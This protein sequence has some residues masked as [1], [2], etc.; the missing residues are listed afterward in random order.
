LTTETPNLEEAPAAAGAQRLTERARRSLAGRFAPIVVLALGCLF[1]GIAL[2]RLDTIYDGDPGVFHSRQIAPKPLEIT[3]GYVVPLLEYFRNLFAESST[4]RD[5]CDRIHVEILCERKTEFPTADAARGRLE[6]YARR[7]FARRTN[8][9]TVGSWLE[10]PRR[11]VV[12]TVAMYPTDRAARA[13]LRASFARR[14]V[15]LRRRRGVSGRP[16]ALSA[17]PEGRRVVVGVVASA[18]S[19]AGAVQ[20]L[21]ESRREVRAYVGVAR[22]V[23]YEAIS[24]GPLV[25]LLALFVSARGIVSFAAA[26]VVAVSAI[27]GLVFTLALAIVSLP[28]AA[29]RRRRRRKQAERRARA[30]AENRLPT[31]A[32]VAT[33]DRD[34][35]LLGDQNRS[36]LV[37]LV[38]LAGFG[39]ALLTEQLFPASLVWGSLILVALYSPK[40]IASE[41]GRSLIAKARKGVRILLGFAV[42]TV[43]FGIAPVGVLTSVYFQVAAAAVGM[44]ILVGHWRDLITETTVGYAK[45]YEDVDAR[46]TVFLAGTGALTLGAA[47]LFLASTGDRNPADHA[48]AKLLGLAGLLIA[49]TAAAHVRA[50]RDAAARERARRR[51]TPYVL[52]LRSFGDDKLRVVS[53][54]VERRG[55]ERLSWRRTELFEDVVARALSAVGPV[56]AIAKPGTGQRDLGAARDSIVVDDWLTA[57]KSYMS[58]AVLVAVVM[59]TSEGL[60]RELDTLAELE[61]VDRVCVLVPPVGDDEI[62]ER[63]ETLRR[64]PSF[65]ALWTPPSEG[66]DD[67]RA[68]V[69]ALIAFRGKRQILI[70]SKRT[71]SAYRAATG[72]LGS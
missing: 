31:Q 5:W 28:F 1:V 52:Y 54:P 50:A 47:S 3:H 43:C 45:W 27:V 26:L 39:I 53:P 9:V 36:V 59:G 41:R 30:L 18:S 61:L 67:W 14:P 56:V 17:W 6:R 58:N 66:D 16:L 10:R 64:Q 21:E 57:V 35:K 25:L 20:Q 69:V 60:V 2:D 38:G 44:L 19:R 37:V 72:R 40:A 32:Q 29:L 7:T 49:F 55:L 62:A 22:V 51:A 24:L 71:A 12:V 34:A 33:V 48:A 70:A 4:G 13:A 42:V 15:V 63:F 11:I 68:K 8:D 23:W 65:A 46:S